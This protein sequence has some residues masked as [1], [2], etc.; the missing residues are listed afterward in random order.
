ME[1]MFL[2]ISFSRSYFNEE[3]NK[4]RNSNKSGKIRIYC[5]II[6][7]APTMSLSQ[8]SNKREKTPATS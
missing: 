4:A 6:N 3:G 5:N 1:S 2:W 8:T 7:Y